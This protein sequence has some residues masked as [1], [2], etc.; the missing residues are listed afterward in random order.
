MVD[1]RGGS[2]CNHREAGV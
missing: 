2:A 1:Q